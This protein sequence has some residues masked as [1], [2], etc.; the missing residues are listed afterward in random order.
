[1]PSFAETAPTVLTDVS[2]AKRFVRGLDKAGDLMEAAASSTA[3]AT[4]ALDT[5]LEREGK[6]DHA[7]ALLETAYWLQSQIDGLVE[8]RKT[9]EG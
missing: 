4:L 5:H 7:Q 2:D 3:L 8:L 9:L 1:V 6:D